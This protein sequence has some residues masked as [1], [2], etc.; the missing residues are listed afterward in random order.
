VPQLPKGVPSGYSGT[1]FLPWIALKYKLPEMNLSGLDSRTWTTR[2]FEG[3]ATIVYLWASW[4]SPCWM[5]LPAVQSLYNTIKDRP[6]IQIVTLSVDEDRAR[7]STFM[8]EKGYNF[9]VIV[10]KSYAERLLP[11]MILGQHWI[12]D[13]TAS[14][15]LQQTYNMLAGRD[16]AF[17]DQA[18]YKLSRVLN[19]RGEV[20]EKNW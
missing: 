7:L 5:H 8:K 4:C 1:P 19:A 18:L 15:R 12:V 11:R 13:G 17:I 14:I 16:Q 20:I 6:G 9:P 10:S 2:D 3:K